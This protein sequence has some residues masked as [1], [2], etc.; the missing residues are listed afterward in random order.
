MGEIEVTGPRALD[1]CQKITTNDAARLAVGR[2]Q[3]TLWCDERGGTIDDTI[4]Y[5]IGPERYLF[6]VN[7]ANAATCLAW[8]ETQ[9]R[10]VEGARVR[11][12]SDETC[13]L[14]LQGPRALAWLERLGGDWLAALPRFGCAE[15]ALLG[16]P[17]F[18]ART[19]YTGEDG[20]ELFVDESRA[21]ELWDGLLERGREEPGLEPIGLGARDTLR[22]EAALPLYGHELRRDVSPLEAGLGWAV[23]L[24]KGDFIGAAALAA[25]KD[26]GVP[27]SLCGLRL[28]EKG[29]AR[30]GYPV[31]A[32]EGRAG[33]VTSGTLSPT[34][35][36][37]IALALIEQEWLDAP[38]NVEIRGRWVAAERVGLPFYRRPT[39]G[40]DGA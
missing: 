15:G 21:V 4:L 9:A 16:V 32:A 7:A 39:P 11:N 37:A 1:L 35:G 5:R 8:I 29:I 18:A 20:V 6:C 27:R 38:L 10:S 17:I 36:R 12:R 22:L 31:Q 30:A 24:D 23:K 13:L 28:V 25:Q 40:R 19:G 33:E 2:A 3:Y 34:L 26:R 14:A